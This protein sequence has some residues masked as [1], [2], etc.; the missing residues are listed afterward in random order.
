MINTK[1]LAP[2]NLDSWNTLLRAATIRGY[3]PILD[4]AKY[5]TKDLTESQQCLRSL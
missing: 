1:L 4:L 2:T 5:L 3:T